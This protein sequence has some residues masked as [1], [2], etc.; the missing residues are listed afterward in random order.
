VNKTWR[1]IFTVL[2]TVMGAFVGWYAADGFLR[3]LSEDATIRSLFARNGSALNGLYAGVFVLVGAVFGF[4]SGGAIFRRVESLGERLNNM[5]ARDKLAL[6]GG[7]VIGLVMT[8]I[9]SLPILVVIP[10]K[11]IAVTVSLLVGVALTYLS[12]AA[13]LSMKEDLRQI[14]APAGSEDDKVPQESFK[15]VDTNVIIDGRIADIARAGF[16]EG[17]IYVPGFVLDELQ[18]IADSADNLRR[19]RGRRGLDTLNQMDKEQKLVVR[20]YDR[21]APTS[22][23][24]DGRLVQLAKALNGALVT[25]DWNLNKVA[26]LQGVPV[27]NINELANALKPVVL[28]GEEMEVAVVKEGREPTQGVGYLDD[29][30][31][32]VVEGG[33]AHLGENVDVIVSSVL[34]TSAGKMIFAHLREEEGG[35]FDRDR[36]VRAYTGGG[37]RR[38]VRRPTK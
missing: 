13:T 4:A 5:S 29:G 21:H 25:N 15:I 11:I 36:G 16:I 8:A 2:L 33:R 10:N 1:L 19:A 27:L 9:I 35:E 3:Y 22:G 34:Q 28:P 31:M 6:I 32:I 17:T 12:T 14:I 23:E 37:S 18:H 38:A 20:T 24:V 7:I 26:E 30:T